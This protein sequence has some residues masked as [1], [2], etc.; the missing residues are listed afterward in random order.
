MFTSNRKFRNNKNNGIRI[1]FKEKSKQFQRKQLKQTLTHEL[2]VQ[3]TPIQFKS[4]LENN[5][6]NTSNEEKIIQQ[7][8]TLSN[9]TNRIMLLAVISLNSTN[10]LT[11]DMINGT[12]DSIAKFTFIQAKSIRV[13]HKIGD[14]K[15]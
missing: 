10:T 6:N 3:I 14:I 5:E 11:N 8:N 13:I 4:T 9:T 1:Q 15:F 7:N 2:I 12:R